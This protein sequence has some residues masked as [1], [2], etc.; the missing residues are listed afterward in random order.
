MQDYSTGYQTICKKESQ[1]WAQVGSREWKAFSSW[2]P[3]WKLRLEEA[4]SQPLCWLE[5][6]SLGKGESSKVTFN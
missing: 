6:E 4:V 1:S 2:E 5:E 3:S